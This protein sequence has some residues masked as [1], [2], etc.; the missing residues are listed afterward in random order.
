MTVF[1]GFGDYRWGCK[2]KNIDDIFVQDS[3]G[4]FP[5]YGVL[6]IPHLYIKMNLQTT[7]F[8]SLSV[9]LDLP[10]W[11]IVAHRYTLVLSEQYEHYFSIQ[12]I[13]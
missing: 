1:I 9:S 13:V 7:A 11:E 8:F 12:P 4:N 6:D 5:P 3:V 10:K 2:A